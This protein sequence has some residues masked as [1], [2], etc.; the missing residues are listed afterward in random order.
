MTRRPL[1]QVL[2]ARAA[3]A[4]IHARPRLRVA[5]ATS[6]CAW[7][8]SQPWLAGVS[9]VLA[10]LLAASWADRNDAAESFAIA[11]RAISTLQ[12]ENQVLRSRIAE[13]AA[14]NKGG[15]L[16]YVIEGQSLQDVADKLNKVSIDLELT[17]YDLMYGD[18]RK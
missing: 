5:I 9:L 3:M 16:F 10:Y 18:E 12:R 2:P 13:Q 6:R 4:L 1:D 15:S 17:R 8:V 11:E 14:Y 7:R